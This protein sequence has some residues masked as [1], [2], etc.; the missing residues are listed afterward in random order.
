[1]KR[2]IVMTVLI[3][4]SVAV[5]AQEVEPNVKLGVFDFIRNADWLNVG[6]VALFTL[7]LTAPYIL[8]ARQKLKQVAE[9]LL[10]IYEF[11]DDKV[12]DKKERAAI[13][14]QFL[15]IIGKKKASVIQKKINDQGG[16][17]KVIRSKTKIKIKTR[18]K[19]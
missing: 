10:L 4:L 1:M 5:F 8:K 18:R 11:T 16:A 12:L 7:G 6:L 14:D 13:I 15:V 2:I 3:V 9:L 17:A 19:Q